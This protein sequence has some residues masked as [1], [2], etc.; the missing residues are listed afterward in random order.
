[1]GRLHS[2]T[3]PGGWKIKIVRE[4]D[5][6][7]VKNTSVHFLR[8]G[9]YPVN[10]QVNPAKAPPSPARVCSC[11]AITTRSTVILPLT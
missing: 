2:V 11:P 7:V 9:K 8:K 1:M 3:A 6:G 10:E 5:C 4:E